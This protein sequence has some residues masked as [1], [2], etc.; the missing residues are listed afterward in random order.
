MICVAHLT[1][2]DLKLTGVPIHHGRHAGGRMQLANLHANS[3]TDGEACKSCC[4][5]YRI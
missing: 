2:C 1:V 5:L 3:L 4:D